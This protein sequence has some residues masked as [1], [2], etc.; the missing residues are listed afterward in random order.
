MSI[1]Y[2]VSI[3]T[4]M[5]MCIHKYIHIIVYRIWTSYFATITVGNHTHSQC[6]IQIKKPEF[7]QLS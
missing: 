1:I 7:F 5:Y 4:R 3:H 6:A 2:Y